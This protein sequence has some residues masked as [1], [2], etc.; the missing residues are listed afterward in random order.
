VDWTGS[1]SVSSLASNPCGVVIQDEVDKFNTTRKRDSEGNV[2]EADACSLADE[3][4]KDSQGI[5]KRFK[6]S[7]PT[8]ASGTIWV[9]LMKSDLRRRFVPCPHCGKFM[10]LAWS[11]EFT[12]LPKINQIT[13]EPIPLAYVKW[14]SKAKNEKGEWDYKRVEETAHFECPGCPGP[15]RDSDKFEMDR[16]GRWIATRFGLPAYFGYHLPSLYSTLP[17][18]AIGRMAVRFLKACRSLD[19]PRGFI[20]SDLAEPYGGQDTI[21]KRIEEVSKVEDCSAWNKLLTVD[22]QQKS[23]HFWYVMRAYGESQIVGLKAG[24]LETWDDLRAVQQ[25]N[26]IPDAG[27]IIDSGYGAKD[28]AEVY[29]TCAQYG[30]FIKDAAHNRSVHLGWMPA[31]GMPGRRKWRNQEGLMVPWYYRPMDPYMGTNLA[32]QVSMDLFE[33]AADHFKDILDRLRRNKDP[34]YHW[35]IS[36]EM[37]TEEYHEHM[38]GQVKRAVIK[39]A[40]EVIEWVK[41]YRQAKDHLFAC[42]VMQVAGAFS[43]GLMS[44]QEVEEKQ[45]EHTPEGKELVTA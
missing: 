42:E 27:V 13:G 18:C 39:Y 15:I 25:E 3:R 44:F 6:A 4:T 32:G 17:E 29:R 8:I 2:V 9:E 37:N 35:T 23:P 40:R 43:L 30:E 33:F 19:G 7:T 28:D 10:V 11:A 20:N 24:S 41:R 5:P 34:R 45:T 12:L 16:K 21:G 36:E 22:C 31:K 26:G 38:R 14:D 1:N